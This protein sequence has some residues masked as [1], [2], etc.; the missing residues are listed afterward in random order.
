MEYFSLGFTHLHQLIKRANSDRSARL[1]S[2][3]QDSSGGYQGV[4]QQ[5]PPAPTPYVPRTVDGDPLPSYAFAIA[6]LNPKEKGLIA[7]GKSIAAIK[8]L[9]DRH[10]TGLVWAKSVV[11]AYRNGPPAS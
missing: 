9:R 5:R 11:D 6:T 10:K 4:F 3:V 1:I 2:V 8:S 7:T